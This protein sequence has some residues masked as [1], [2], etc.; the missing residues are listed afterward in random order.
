VRV[1]N[2][3]GVVDRAVEENHFSS[4]FVDI[5]EFEQQVA[6]LAKRG[7][8]VGLDEID[9]A[10]SNGHRL[11]DNA[12]HVSFDDGYRNN[13]RAAEI[14]DRHHV[15]WSLFVVVDSVLDS[16]QPW[17][18]RLADAIDATTNVRM[19]DGSVFEMSAAVAKREFSRRAKVE[20]MSAPDA[21]Q[22][23]AVDRV[24]A[25]PGI[26]VPDEPRWPLLDLAEV[27]E[28]RSAGVTIGNH[29]ARHRNLVRC[30]D[31]DLH[32]EVAGAHARLE[33][34]LDSPVRYFAYPDGRHDRRVCRAVGEHH[35]L[36][37]ATWT[38]RAP[39]T[40]LAIRRY[41]PTTVTEVGAIVDAPEPWYGRRWLR[42]NAPWR[43][44]EIAR[45]IR[46][47]G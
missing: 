11:P 15:P 33:A 12:V 19:D 34:A 17:F 13:L 36:G 46:R 21:D 18:L 28:L 37:L 8:P 41:E 2:F 4:L 44:R 39:D 35:A 3:H 22:D 1:L 43:A 20:I 26:R 10:L 5:A 31:A 24:L 45:R 23:A 47:A 9:A 29:S 16:Y 7:H 14:L 38:L 42:W 32:A 6:L 25:R 30:P 40:P 27:R